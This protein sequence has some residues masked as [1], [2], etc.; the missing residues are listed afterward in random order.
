[1]YCR[2][3]RQNKEAAA[4]GLL[5]SHAQQG[6][7]DKDIEVQQDAQASFLYLMTQQSYYCITMIVDFAMCVKDAAT[8]HVCK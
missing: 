5:E 6:P 7:R 8:G 3:L 2:A 4:L 1:M